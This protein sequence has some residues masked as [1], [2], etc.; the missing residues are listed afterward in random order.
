MGRLHCRHVAWLLLVSGA[1]AL[2]QTTESRPEVPP[3][4]STSV[5]TVDAP[6]AQIVDPP[7]AQATPR[8]PDAPSEAVRLTTHQKFETFV[9]RTYS[10]Y[11]FASA[12]F[13]ATWAQMWGDYYD[14]GGGMEGWGKRYGASLA[15]TEIRSFFS[16]FALP[17]VFRQD[18]RYHPS[19]KKGLWP[20]TWYAGTRVFVT[21][22]D[23]NRP[24]FNYSEVLGVLFTS[25]VQNSYY[26]RRDRGFPETLQRFIGGVG[27]DASSN[28]LREFNPEINKL[29]RKIIPKKAQ[30]WEEKLPESVKQ[31]VGRAMANEE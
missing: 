27:S 26:P 4:E 8:L 12:G 24:M 25:S 16:S 31:G 20:R 2:A 11:T 7:K 28:L 10:P 18:P 13:S 30:K 3:A 17:V 6:K 15:N 29:A 23:N 9:K 14:Y 1:C 19:K 21:R 5:Q 22:S